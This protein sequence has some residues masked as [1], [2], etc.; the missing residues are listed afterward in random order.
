[1][2]DQYLFINFCFISLGKSNNSILRED[3][4]CLMR[5]SQLAAKQYFF[6]TKD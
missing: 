1:M 6:Q 3:V 2:L 5:I 4:F